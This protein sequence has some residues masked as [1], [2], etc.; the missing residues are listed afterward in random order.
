MAR[1]DAVV[2]CITGT[3]RDI[4][5]SGEALFAAVAN[6]S[7]APRI[8]Y[9][10][11]IAAYG[12]ARGSVDELSPLR[13][14]L[15]DY[16]AAKATV[17]NRATHFPNVVR[18]RPGIVYGPRSGWWSEHIAQL[19]MRRRLGDLGFI[20][21]GICN[22]VH[23]DDVAAAALRAIELPAAAGEAFNL[24]SPNPPTWN[25]YFQ[26]YAQFLG[27]LPLR[28]I[29]AAGLLLE[30]NLY[31][32]ALKVAEKLLRGSSPWAERPAL[33]PWLLE[34]CKHDIRMQVGKAEQ[35]LGI[36]WRTLDAGLQET[37]AWFLS[38]RPA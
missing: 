32:P 38:S 37:A 27:A 10:S 3:S 28:R 5:T 24:G 7:K 11:S 20:G 17:E 8:V 36:R 35:T 19:L 13:G 26:R 29:S 6:T 22:A 23:V 1:A 16:S 15:G 12:S 25:E 18:L 2:S 21:Q 33:R 4:V 31:G 34:L 30:L 9:L 14:D